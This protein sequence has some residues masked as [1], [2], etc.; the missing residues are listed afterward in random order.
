MITIQNNIVITGNVLLGKSLML[1]GNIEV[2]G[3]LEPEIQK[4]EGPY[5]VIPKYVQQNLSTK[6][7]MMKNDVSVEE[8]PVYKTE[9]LG[10]GYTVT[11]GGN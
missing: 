1:Q 8:I 9:N 5:N 7:L 2:I 11:I 6:N 3:K 4:Y 10:G